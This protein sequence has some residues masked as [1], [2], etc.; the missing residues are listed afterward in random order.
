MVLVPRFAAWLSFENSQIAKHK[1]SLC[2][3]WTL[4]HG[5]SN[6]RYNYLKT[7]VYLNY[8]QKFSPYL[9]EKKALPYGKIQ[10]V[11]DLW[12][13]GG[14]PVFNVRLIRT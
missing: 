6:D 12:G 3:S 2:K 13:G 9:R 10:A 4:R 8:T 14:V 1:I 7:Q 11:K 5:K